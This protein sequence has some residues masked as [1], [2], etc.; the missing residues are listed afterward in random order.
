MHVSRRFVFFPF[1]YNAQKHDCLDQHWNSMEKEREG[2]GTSL[3]E[4]SAEFGVGR[5]LDVEIALDLAR[6]LSQFFPARFLQLQIWIPH[7]DLYWGEMEM[8]DS[9]RWWRR[10]VCN[11][12]RRMIVLKEQ[13]S[14]NSVLL[15]MR[16]D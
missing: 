6:F 3:G 7:S 10:I 11:S 4:S 15:V 8:A 13:V 9:L 1:G 5:E 12:S 16:R 14:F 2:N